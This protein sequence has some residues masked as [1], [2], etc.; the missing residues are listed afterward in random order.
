MRFLHTSAENYVL[1][2][3]HPK[4]RIGHFWKTPKRASFLAPDGLSFF[5]GENGQTFP[6]C[7]T[8]FLHM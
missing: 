4:M 3:M 1:A 6:L 5:E 2:K 7:F 8:H